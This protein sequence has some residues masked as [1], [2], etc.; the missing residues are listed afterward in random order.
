MRDAAGGS[1]DPGGP[2]EGRTGWDRSGLTP[3]VRCERVVRRRW[4]EGE[5]DGLDPPEV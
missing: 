1:G 5:R 4:E 2:R 3:G